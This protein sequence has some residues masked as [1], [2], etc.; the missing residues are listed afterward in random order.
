[1]ASAT[2]EGDTVRTMIQSVLALGLLIAA[3]I[4]LTLPGLL[5]TRPRFIRLAVTGLFIIV[6]STTVVG[7]VGNHLPTAL[8]SGVFGLICALV[9]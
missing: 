8:V 6:T 4:A 3:P 7:I 9:G 1:M 5:R 2:G